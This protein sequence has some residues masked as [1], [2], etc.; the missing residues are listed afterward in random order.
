MDTS[1]SPLPSYEFHPHAV[2]CATSGA[3]EPGGGPERR[4]LGDFAE[5]GLTACDLRLSVI[6]DHVEKAL[7]WVTAEVAS[8]LT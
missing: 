4:F 1:G 3:R 5:A 8:K 7:E 6:V 2:T